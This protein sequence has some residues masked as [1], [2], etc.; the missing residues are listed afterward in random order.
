[1]AYTE[2]SKPPINSNLSRKRKE[3]D[4]NPSASVSKKPAFIKK[5]T[6]GDD[7]CRACQR[8]GIPDIPYSPEHYTT[9]H[10]STRKEKEKLNALN[11]IDTLNEIDPYQAFLAEP[12]NDKPSQIAEA[13]EERRRD[14]EFMHQLDEISKGFKTNDG[15]SSEQPAPQ[16]SST[17]NGTQG[18]NKVKSPY[19]YPFEMTPVTINTIPTNAMVDTGANPSFIS[20]EFWMKHAITIILETTN[21]KVS[22]GGLLEK[23]HGTCQ[24]VNSKQVKS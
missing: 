21:N 14:K 16:R 22:R 7:N 13:L 9:V 15:G 20:K 24:S 4:S 23:K 3:I 12:S 2:Y 5:E 1:L 6:P 18:L 8:N 17:S 10:G 11:E 19:Y